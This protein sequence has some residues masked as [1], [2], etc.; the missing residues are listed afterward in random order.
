MVGNPLATRSDYRL[1]VAARVPQL[2]VLDGKDLAGERI[3][4]G[5]LTS[6]WFPQSGR[7]TN[8]DYMNNN[9]SNNDSFVYRSLDKEG[10][11]ATSQ[12]QQRPGNTFSGGDREFSL[13]IKPLSSHLANNSPRSLQ[14]SSHKQKLRYG[15]N[16]QET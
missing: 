16:H 6:K 13:R 10:L 12:S 5:E 9:N 7:N 11:Q 8:N 14:Y 4:L 15:Y 3:K 1:N 2:S